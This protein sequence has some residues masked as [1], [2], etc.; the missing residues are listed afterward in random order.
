MTL[1]T[2]A[3]SYLLPDDLVAG[4]STIANQIDSFHSSISQDY[5]HT[6]EI[7]YSLQSNSFESFQF[8]Q[9][10]I[11]KHHFKIPVSVCYAGIKGVAISR[12]TAVKHSSGDY[13]WFLDIACRL[14]YQ[15][16]PFIDY[17]SCYE[18]PF[19]YLAT[20]NILRIDISKL[21]GDMPCKILRVLIFS[22]FD[23]FKIIAN[24]ATYNILVSSRF[25]AENPS[26][27]FDPKL[28]LG[29]Y[30]HQSDE[31]LFLIHLFIAMVKSRIF[32]FYSYPMVSLSAESKSHLASGPTLIASIESK[33][34]VLAKSFSSIYFTLPF[35][36]FLTLLFAF[37]FRSILGLLTPVRSVV[38]GYNVGISVK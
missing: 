14:S 18:Q 2:L 12:N 34:Y 16:D 15:I 21:L 38:K 4:A 6:V 22:L 35:L 20:P 3:V 9:G 10:V 25:L 31:A 13:V 26:L 36:P 33:G 7:C 32:S 30:Y 37:K 11:G 27:R 1:L 19:L 23:V 5:Y 24:S 29:T 8:V 28:G 17:L